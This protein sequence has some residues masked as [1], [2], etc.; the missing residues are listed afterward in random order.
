MSERR[1][2]AAAHPGRAGEHHL[3]VPA[4]PRG[5]PTTRE[6]GTPGF[7]EFVASLPGGRGGE[8]RDFG[9]IAAFLCSESAKYLTG[10]ALSVDGGTDAGLI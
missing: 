5:T 10:V 9:R 4:A 8:P 1:P 2:V 3:D 7:D 6:E